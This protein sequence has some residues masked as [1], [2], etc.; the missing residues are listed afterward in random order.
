MIRVPS[1]EECNRRRLRGSL[2]AYLDGT[3]TLKWVLGVIGEQAA[4]RGLANIVLI[5]GF[6]K[7]WGTV[8]FRELQEGLHDKVPQGSSPGGSECSEWR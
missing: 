1:P 6:P 8:R 4:Q 2:Q 3:C 7:Y 5:H